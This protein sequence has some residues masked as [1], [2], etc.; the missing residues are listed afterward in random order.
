MA[1]NM[2]INDL[3]HKT[4]IFKK[5]KVIDYF[6]RNLI[7][8][9]NLMDFYRNLMGFV[10]NSVTEPRHD[11][12]WRMLFPT[13]SYKNWAVQSHKTAKC[14]KFREKDVYSL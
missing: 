2:K 7:I 4:I 1:I 11:K 14:M 3:T 8:N 5:R 6:N 10:C 9:G 13:N 12:T